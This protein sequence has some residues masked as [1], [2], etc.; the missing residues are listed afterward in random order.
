MSSV[1]TAA[2][3]LLMISAV[4]SALSFVVMAWDKRAAARGRWRVPEKVLHVLELL[5][6]WPGSLLA[7]SWLRHKSVKA[8]YRVVRGLMI[9][10][11]SAGVGGLL[12]AAWQGG[13]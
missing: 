9:L 8:G 1:I 4:M 13:G 5:G 11:H 3:V 12:Y 7:S 6:G 2:G 10:L